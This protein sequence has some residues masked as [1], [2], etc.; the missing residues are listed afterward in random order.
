[1]TPQNA[2]VIGATGGLGAALAAH[3]R[4]A[5]APVTT[6]SRRE[7][8]L[9]ITDEATVIAAAKHLSDQTF[10]LI[11]DATGALVVDGVDPE[12]RMRELDPAIMLRSYAVNAVGPAM[13]LKHF[14]ERLPRRGPAAFATLSARLGSIGDNRLGG[15]TSY[16]AAKAGL[17][18]IV[19]S[20]SVEIARKR[21]E[22]VVVALHP[23]TVETAL[24]RR[25]ARGRFTATPPEAAAQLLGALAGLGPGDTGGFFAYDGQSVPW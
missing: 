7:D 3:L 19:R 18:Q 13:L 12:R 15:W 1:M 25:F 23:G 10:D 22:A 6:L 14:A 11:L 20:A 9:D 16:R 4:A 21:P 2:L 8:G 5:G 17:N 24:T